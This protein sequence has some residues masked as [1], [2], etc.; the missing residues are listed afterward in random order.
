MTMMNMCN[1]LAIEDLNSS[2]QIHSL[3]LAINKEISNICKGKYLTMM[4]M[5]HLQ[6]MNMKGLM[7]R[8][9][10]NNKKKNMIHQNIIMMRN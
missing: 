5:N 9:T 1:C 6:M 10:T 2:G 7:M 8:M 4:N 3:L